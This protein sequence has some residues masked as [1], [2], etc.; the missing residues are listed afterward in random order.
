MRSK[1]LAAKAQQIN[2]EAAR[3]IGKNSLFFCVLFH[4][5]PFKATEQK[6]GLLVQELRYSHRLFWKKAS[7]WP[8]SVQW[9]LRN[10]KNV[11]DNL[12]KR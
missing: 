8:S 11:V 10:L 6:H 2:G 5:L 3:R 1:H 4:A 7:Q 9:T 12:V